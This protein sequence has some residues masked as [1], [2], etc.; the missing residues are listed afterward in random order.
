VNA[1]KILID[2][3]PFFGGATHL[4]WAAADALIIPVRV[5]QHSLEALRLTL[6]MLKSEKMDFR[7]FNTECYT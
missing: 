1:Y 5:D 3:S 2:T 4:A 7:K 6:E